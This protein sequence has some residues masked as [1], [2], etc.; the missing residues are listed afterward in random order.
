MVALGGVMLPRM[1]VDHGAGYLNMELRAIP[2]RPIWR[3]LAL[4]IGVLSLA[5]FGW[6]MAWG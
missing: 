5:A 4:N 6:M 3:G 1:M 2:L